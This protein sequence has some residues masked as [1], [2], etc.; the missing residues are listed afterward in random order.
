MADS[1]ARQR[2]TYPLAS[3]NFR[4]TVG[5]SVMSFTEVSGLSLEYETLTY[6]HG[7]SFWEGESIVKFRYD[8]YVPVTL[9]KGVVAG[10]NDISP[11]L[12]GAEQKALSVSL[13]DE[14][15]TAVVTWQLKKALVVKLEMPSLQVSSNDAAIETLTLM[16]TGISFEHH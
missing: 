15:G 12:A 1:V 2:T 8:K 11:W 13:C 6:K 4:V 7:L 16:V 10:M 3:Y 5:E 14:T 9:K